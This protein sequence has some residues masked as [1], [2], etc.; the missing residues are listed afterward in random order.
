MA[1]NM[2]IPR[3]NISTKKGL[4]FVK[5]YDNMHIQYP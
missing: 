4:Y 1:A 2:L 5:I 3:K